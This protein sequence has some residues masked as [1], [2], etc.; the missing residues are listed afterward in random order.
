M[1][2]TVRKALSVFSFRSVDHFLV[3]NFKG[4]S[5]GMG[6]MK[7]LE[8]FCQTSAVGGACEI[9]LNGQ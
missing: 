2:R 8:G 1:D 7:S 5:W 3:I 4:G 9:H 6:E